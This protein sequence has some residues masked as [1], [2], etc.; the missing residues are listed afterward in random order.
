MI[1]KQGQS[2]GFVTQADFF[3]QNV[4][5]FFAMHAMTCQLALKV[6]SLEHSS[7]ETLESNHKHHL[8]P[9]WF[10][11]SLMIRFPQALGDLHFDRVS[12]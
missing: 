7:L 8:L 5:F 3:L 6:T 12:Q 1:I 10:L 9:V 11:M 2:G 4:D